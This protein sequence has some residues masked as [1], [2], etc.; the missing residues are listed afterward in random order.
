MQIKAEYI[1]KHG[2]PIPAAQQMHQELA[3]KNGMLLIESPSNQVN[4]TGFV[5]DFLFKLGHLT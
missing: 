4:R 5:G 1:A 3:H 2:G